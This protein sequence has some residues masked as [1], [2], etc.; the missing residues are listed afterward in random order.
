MPSAQVL[1]RLL[2]S[3]AAQFCVLGGLLFALYALW[4]TPPPSELVVPEELVRALSA[5]HQQTHGAP[6]SADALRTAVDAWVEAE[7]LF[8]E[9]RAL[10]LERGDPVVRRRLTQS[11]R[12]LLEGRDE[13]P[14]DGEL[15]AH[16]AAHPRRFATEDELDVE[17]LFFGQDA[18]MPARVL[19]RLE[20]GADASRLGLPFPT[21]RTLRAQTR[22]RLAARFGAPFAD[23]VLALPAGSWRGPIVSAF[24]QHLVRVTRR[25]HAA[26]PTLDAVRERVRADFEAQR[27]AQRLTEGLRGLRARYRVTL[28]AATTATRAER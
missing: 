4:R 5:Q 26:P 20:R 28:P 23:A 14:T 15:R 27:R 24:G 25:S 1:R 22:T 12:F 18:S 2:R 9:A 7:I 8:R 11:M 17:H 19:A 10:G 3:P 21:G 13:A 16:L 6:P